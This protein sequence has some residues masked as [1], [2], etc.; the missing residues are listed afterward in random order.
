M[1]HQPCK[2]AP[3]FLLL[4][5]TVLPG[6]VCSFAAETQERGFLGI[7]LSQAGSRA[8]VLSV[9]PDGPA[10]DVD[11]QPGDF[12]VAFNGAEFFFDKSVDLLKGLRWVTAGTPVRLTIDRQGQFHE[13]EVI[14]APLGR[15]R[16]A[17]LDQWISKAEL[18]EEKERKKCAFDEFE[19]M[20]KA[21]PV[22]VTF[23]RRGGS[24]SDV[25]ENVVVSSSVALP[26][27][28]DL[29]HDDPMIR[30]LVE[31]LKPGDQAKVV[32][33]FEKGMMHESVTEAPA[34]VEP[35]FDQYTSTIQGLDEKKDWPA[36]LNQRN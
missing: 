7:H 6:A 30:L 26:P 4:L 14:P 17:A 35:V 32:Y 5:L 1:T 23:T 33:S 8:E 9:V 3:A 15:D 36:L 21:S 22:E 12:V 18:A 34:Y 28:L 25:E 27:D 10:A 31:T 16:Q 13:V 20:F 29:M 24:D 11:L 19:Q 2:L